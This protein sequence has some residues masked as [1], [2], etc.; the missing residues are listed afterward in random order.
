[1]QTLILVGCGD[2][3]RRAAPWL[4]QRF[5]VIALL[6]DP[7]KMA[8]WRKLGC[9]PM[10]ADLDQRKTLSR[11]RGIADA[12]LHLAPP[13]TSG[14]T[15]TRTAHL[16]QALGKTGSLP[17]RLVYVSTTG[18]Y[19]DC[20]GAQIDETRPLHAESDRARR[21]VDAEHQLRTWGQET[22]CAVTILRAPGIY[23]HDR[24]PTARLQQGLPAL[25]PEDDVFTNHIHADDLARA[26]CLALFRG[27]AG[28]TFN[29]TDDTDMKMGD[30]FD[31]VADA[32]HLPR[33]PRIPQQALAAH[34]SPVQR[35][36]MS[37]SRRISN[38]RLKRELR[39]QLRYPT[40]AST[41]NSLSQHTESD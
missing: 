17:A 30:Y 34:L 38:Q 40:V 21:R 8:E 37:E 39:L 6:R 22:G 28:R 24:L 7:A 2:V 36:F 20:Q 4:T 32:C 23:A 9:R 26:C 29:V 13:P 5:R 19:G 35:S 16:L 14:A 25:T 15:D 3:A 18:V 1:M 31:A 11:L 41:L 10:L 27:K 12:V 33:P